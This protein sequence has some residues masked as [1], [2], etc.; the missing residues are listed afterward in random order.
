MI[1]TNV[2]ARQIAVAGAI[3]ACALAAGCHRQAAA[4]EPSA[5]AV[6][7][8]APAAAE[9]KAEAPGLAEYREGKNHVMAGNYAASILSFE[10]AIEQ[11]RD[12]AEAWYQLGASR[13]RMALQQVRYDEQS[14]VRMFREAVDAK[15]TAQQLMS[16]GKYLVWDEAQREQAWSD[17]SKALE[18]VDAV[19]ADEPSLIAAMHMWAG[20]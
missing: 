16:M 15:R 17:L 9:E 12:F 10:R 13:S 5:A 14:A 6:S 8:P 1:M 20:G 18:D 11:N 7:A 19:L 4:P 2:W 3:A